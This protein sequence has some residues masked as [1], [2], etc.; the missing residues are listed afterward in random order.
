MSKLF[1]G[2]CRKF[3][4]PSVEYCSDKSV[5]IYCSVCKTILSHT[6]EFNSE[7]EVDKKIYDEFKK[8]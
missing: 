3:T 5:K 8:R 4:I 2:K 6:V 7:V 1:C